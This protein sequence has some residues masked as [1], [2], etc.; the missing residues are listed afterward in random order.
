MGLTDKIIEYLATKL[1]QSLHSDDS[2]NNSFPFSPMEHDLLHL[3]GVSPAEI[4]T[5]EQQKLGNVMRTTLAKLSL[6]NMQDKAITPSE[7]LMNSQILGSLDTST[8]R[9]IVISKSMMTR[10]ILNQLDTSPEGIRAIS[11]SRY[12]GRFI[13]KF[14]SDQLTTLPDG[15]LM[16]SDGSFISKDNLDWIFPNEEYTG[17]PRKKTIR[18]DVYSDKYLERYKFLGTG[19]YSVVI[20]DKEKSFVYKFSRTGREETRLLYKLSGLPIQNNTIRIKRVV[21]FGQVDVLGKVDILELE[22]ISGKSLHQRLGEEIFT[23]EKTREYSSGI[24]NGLLELRQA[25]IW[26]HRD[27]RPA[28]IMIDEEKDRAV[29]IDL[30]IATTDKDALAED[31]RRFGSPSGRR[32][33]DLNSLG[34]VVYKMAT[35]EHIF[36][37]SKYME[38]T[39]FADKLRDHRDWIYERPEERLLPYLRR[40]EETVKDRGL[41]EIVNF[42]L[43]SKGKDEDYQQLRKKLGDS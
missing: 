4:P 7:K 43:T 31:N 26:H 6:W 39:I 30:G 27:I 40:V 5:K 36:A 11:K 13:K 23:K 32:A 19:R 3:L 12:S 28:N 10:Q 24:L 2:I 22:Y 38:R 21:E 1:I 34:Q 37:E 33:N 29:I 25:G 16:F 15:K 9:V 17:A 8:E 35:G 42:C 18:S 20:L 41:C 14:I